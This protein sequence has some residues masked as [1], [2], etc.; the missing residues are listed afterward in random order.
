MCR[1]ISCFV[2]L[3]FTTCCFAHFH[4]FE[5]QIESGF[6]VFS[7]AESE[8]MSITSETKLTNN[9]TTYTIK[10]RSTFWYFVNPSQP[11]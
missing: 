4:I 1:L 5:H 6:I 7:K 9:K 2:T 11:R 8:Q 3:A 10:L